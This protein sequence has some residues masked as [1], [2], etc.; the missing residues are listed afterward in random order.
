MSSSRKL[1]CRYKAFQQAKVRAF[2]PIPFKEPTKFSRV[3]RKYSSTDE[4]ISAKQ[5]AGSMHNKILMSSSINIRT[6]R[7]FPNKLNWRRPREIVADARPT[8]ICG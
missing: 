3:V 2:D 7:A 1:V 6:A 8:R 5:S 4:E